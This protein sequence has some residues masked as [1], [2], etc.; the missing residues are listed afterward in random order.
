MNHESY[1]AWIA[2]GCFVAGM[3]VGIGL[4]GV[5]DWLARKR[6]GAL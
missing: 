6:G 4:V 1:Q 5:A 2:L 3:G